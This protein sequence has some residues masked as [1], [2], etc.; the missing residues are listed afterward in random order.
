[1]SQSLRELKRFRQQTDVLSYPPKGPHMVVYIFVLD[2]KQ[3]KVYAP[4]LDR[5]LDYVPKGTPLLSRYVQRD[6]WA[7]E[8]ILWNTPLRLLK[9]P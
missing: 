4:N 3:I 9:I 6:I 2:Q 1:M 5:A 7:D 8:G